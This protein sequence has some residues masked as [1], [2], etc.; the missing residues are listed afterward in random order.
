MAFNERGQL[1]PNAGVTGWK[2]E[3]QQETTELDPRGQPIRGYRVYFTTGK[4]Q[5][6]SV[7]VAL[8]MYN[9]QNVR[10]AVAS[11]AGQ[12]DETASLS[13]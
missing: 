1:V 13:G 4:G 6:G 12:L 3:S 9:P 11:H 7:F 8:S 10:A 5:H 2:V